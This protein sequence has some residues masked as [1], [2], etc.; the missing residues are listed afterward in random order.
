MSLGSHSPVN[1]CLELYIFHQDIRSDEATF[2]AEHVFYIRIFTI[3]QCMLVEKN[4][5]WVM[6]WLAYNWKYGVH[7]S[8]PVITWPREID[9]MIRIQNIQISASSSC[10]VH[11][12][13]PKLRMF[14]FKDL[15]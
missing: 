15:L 3:T 10:T 14:N 8:F 2:K 13:T 5:S 1:K 11:G 12:K 7:G 9:Y 4:E 6:Q